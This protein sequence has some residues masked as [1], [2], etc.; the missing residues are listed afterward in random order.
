MRFVKLLFKVLHDFSL[1]SF[2]LY[3]FK[4]TYSTNIFSA[5]TGYLLI[6]LILIDNKDTKMNKTLFLFSKE[7]MVIS[8]GRG[9]V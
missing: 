3:K 6:T 5:S 9:G 7:L 4:S 2:L 1:S 8:G